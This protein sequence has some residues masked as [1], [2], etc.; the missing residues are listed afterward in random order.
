[1]IVAPRQLLV[2]WSHSVDSSSVPVPLPNLPKAWGHTRLAS[3]PH[4]AICLWWTHRLTAVWL[5]CWSVR[6]SLSVC[7]PLIGCPLTSA[8]PK[9]FTEYME[10]CYHFY[11]R[12]SGR[13][14]HFVDCSRL[15]QWSFSSNGCF[16]SAP[17]YSLHCLKYTILWG[18]FSLKTL[19]IF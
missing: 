4:T 13:N 6:V 17:A 15:R 11:T 9:A 8:L 19:S 3:I 10:K 14:S 7:L 5:P 1:M 16:S 18:T 2:S 12:I